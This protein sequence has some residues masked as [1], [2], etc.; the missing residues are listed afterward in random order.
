M[1]FLRGGREAGGGG[2]HLLNSHRVFL[3]E[4]MQRSIYQVSLLVCN[5]SVP[6]PCIYKYVFRLNVHFG[7]HFALKMDRFFS[8]RSF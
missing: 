8:K 6:F 2:H 3:N 1:A 7:N 4:H 5:I